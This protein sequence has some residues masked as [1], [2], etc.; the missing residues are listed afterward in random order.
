[1]KK[2]PKISDAEWQIMQSLW[3]ESPQTANRLVN[4]LAESTNW[5][6]RTIKTLLS[7]LVNKQAL[8]FTKEGRVYHYYP[9]V[10]AKE[11]TR[12]ARNY[13]LTKV[14]NGALKPMLTAFIEDENLT[15][16]EIT[17]L[18]RILDQ[19]GKE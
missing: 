12:A 3:Q 18:K 19:K 8:S 15:P 4:Q 7:R 6:P 2:I 14:Y 11:C 10:S 13:F 16:E 5:N 1:M 17:E 9:L